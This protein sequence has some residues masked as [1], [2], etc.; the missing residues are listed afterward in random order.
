MPRSYERPF[1]DFV[2]T[3]VAEIHA[4]TAG[5]QIQMSSLR[6]SAGGSR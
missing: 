5:S 2:S 1:S 3:V 6:L 4:L